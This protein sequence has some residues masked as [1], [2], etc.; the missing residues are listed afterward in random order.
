MDGIEIGEWLG[1]KAEGHLNGWI[2]VNMAEYLT[3]Q[4][5]RQMGPYT[6]YMY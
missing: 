5:N 2:G 1:C 3:E 4:M 6:M